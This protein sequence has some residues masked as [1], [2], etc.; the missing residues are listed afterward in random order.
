MF[1]AW[2][3]FCRLDENVSAPW[4]LTQV[5]V[6]ALGAS[7]L[8]TII[9][10]LWRITLGPIV[11]TPWAASHNECVQFGPPWLRSTSEVQGIK[12]NSWARPATEDASC[13]DLSASTGGESYF[14]DEL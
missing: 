12:H 13:E 5:T 10:D 3:Q 2:L 7:M 4:T 1:R 9:L 6:D 14:S 8:V 11:D